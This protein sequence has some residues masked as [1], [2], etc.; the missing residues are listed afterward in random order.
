MSIDTVTELNGFY[1]DS[2]ITFPVGE[3]DEESKRLLEVTE[4]S[5]DIGIETGCSR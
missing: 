2:A 4:K 3:I 1:G 5:R